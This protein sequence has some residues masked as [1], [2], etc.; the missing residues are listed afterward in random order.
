MKDVSNSFMTNPEMIDKSKRILVIGDVML[1]RYYEGSV[2]RISPEAPVPILK[3]SSDFDR[4]GGA[5]NV[6]INIARLGLHATLLGYV[7]ADSAAEALAAAVKAA[8][9]D[10]EPITSNSSPTILKLRARSQ[11]QQIIRIDF[12]ESFRGED[13]ASL[14]GKLEAIVETFDAIILSDYAK[15]TLEN[16]AAMIGI[17]ARKN[18]PVFVDPKG[19]DFSRYAGATV[20]TPNLPEFVT[21][22]GRHLNEQ[23]FECAAQKLRRDLQLKHI[24]VTRGEDGMSLFSETGPAYSVAAD[25]REVYDVTGAGDTVIA[26][27]AAAFA[28]GTTIEQAVMLSNIA[29]GLVVAKTGTSAVTTEDVMKRLKETIKQ[30]TDDPLEAIKVAKRAGDTIVMTN[31]CFDIL[32][33][34]HVS[35][36][37]RARAL[38][39]K[40]VVAINSDASVTRL[41]GQGRPINGLEDRMALLSALRCVDWVIPFDGSVDNDGVLHDTPLTL[42]R[43]VAPDILVKGGDYSVET[44]VGAVDVLGYGGQVELISLVEGRSTTAIAE[45]LAGL[46]EKEGSQ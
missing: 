28:S 12:E 17:C 5:A 25:A 13:H 22:T 4:P 43:K 9:I 26:T 1:D 16:S 7:G 32:H 20:I 31:G 38:G 3:V 36:L 35:Y 18:K 41:K 14:L 34:G 6:A 46:S 27:L 39:D 23:E 24:L 2:D 21:V 11:K 42:I 37:E 15:G 19:A 10:F 29:A 45:R 8:G 30:E 44:I 40:L 33:L